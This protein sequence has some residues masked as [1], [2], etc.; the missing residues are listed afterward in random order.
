M[1]FRT[2]HY[3]D[4]EATVHNKHKQ[5]AQPGHNVKLLTLAIRWS[6]CSASSYGEIRQNTA[7]TG[8]RLFEDTCE[9]KYS[10]NKTDTADR[11]V[12]KT[13]DS[14]KTR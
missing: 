4:K 11:Q 14:V 9:S 6:T 7:P 13:A 12:N 8:S 1:L 3:Q 10:I 5:I 2:H